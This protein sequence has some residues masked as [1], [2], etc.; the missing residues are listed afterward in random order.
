MKTFLKRI[1]QLIAWIMLFP[2]GLVLPIMFCDEKYRIIMMACGV[3]GIFLLCLTVSDKQDFE[4]IQKFM[5]GE[6]VK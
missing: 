3:F 4:K 1:V 5:F 6:K 2:A